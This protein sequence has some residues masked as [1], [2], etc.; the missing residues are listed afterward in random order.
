MNYLD[1]GKTFLQADGSISERRHVRLPS[2]DGEGIRDV[3]RR[4]GA[5]LESPDDAMTFW[6]W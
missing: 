1:L 3:G 4:N 2:P 5:H 6:R